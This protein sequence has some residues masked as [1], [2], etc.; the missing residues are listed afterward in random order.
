MAVAE[1]SADEVAKEIRLKHV[2]EE[3]NLLTIRAERVDSLVILHCQGRLVVG[4]E[5]GLLCSVMRCGSRE[6]IVDLREVTA[7]DGAGVAALISLQ[8][9]GF[10][11]TLADPTP[12]VREVLASTDL[13]SVFEIAATPG[14]PNSIL[15][16]A[17]A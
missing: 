16:G 13:D 8:A 3:D 9:A 5:T 15:E 4:H 6:V 12:I 2:H 7:I 17:V 11:L 1:F 10:Y 14:T